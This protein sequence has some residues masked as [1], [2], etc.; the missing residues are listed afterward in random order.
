MAC[1]SRG[2]LA[3]ADL[4]SHL[5]V[6]PPGN[7]PVKQPVKSPASLPAKPAQGAVGPVPAGPVKATK[8]GFDF[9]RAINFAAGEKNPAKKMEIGRDA[10]RMEQAVI[11]ETTERQKMRGGCAARPGIIDTQRGD[12]MTWE[13][14]R[15][16]AAETAFLQVSLLH[17]QRL[18]SLRLRLQ[19]TTP[20]TSTMSNAS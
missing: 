8:L 16:A 12:W 10:L 11:A 15:A 17:L 19:A 3:D 1:R 6:R 13:E 18:S 2:P 7:A 9:T 4:P 5:P 14:R 20:N